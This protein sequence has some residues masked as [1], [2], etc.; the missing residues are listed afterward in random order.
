MKENDKS[1]YESELKIKENEIIYTQNKTNE[2]QLE[3]AN[4]DKSLE[5]LDS[6]IEITGQQQ[7]MTLQ[8]KVINFFHVRKKNMF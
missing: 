2:I 4:I 8:H 6:I 5:S 1:N 7:K 3:I